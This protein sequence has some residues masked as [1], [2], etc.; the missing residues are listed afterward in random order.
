MPN[1][2]RGD[3]SP[4]YS[5]KATFSNWHGTPQLFAH[6]VRV[7]HGFTSAE[8]PERADLLIDVKVEDDHECFKS[9]D[10]FLQNITMEA[11]RTFTGIE[12]TSSSEL[13]KIHLSL[14]WLTPWWSA[15]KEDNSIVELDVV[16]A[17]LNWAEYA[18]QTIVAAI[19]RG[20][21]KVNE[22][23]KGI[24]LALCATLIG[25]FITIVLI[26]LFHFRASALLI[27]AAFPLMIASVYLGAWLIPPI[28]IAPKGSTRLWRAIKLVGPLVVAI[29]I[30]GLT[31][32]LF[33]T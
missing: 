1:E 12:I 24:I 18:C 28:E 6:I 17:D 30:A 5:A 33:G 3:E 32:K 31:K 7:L 20:S 21:G 14:R 11:L 4:N 9:I 29:A 23:A 2:N 25:I 27:F 16:G 26:Y 15:K 19:K 13:G 22:T 10:D 8:Q